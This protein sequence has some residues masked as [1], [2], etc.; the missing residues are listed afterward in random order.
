MVK[1]KSE[2]RTN[3]AEN[4]SSAEDPTERE[5]RLRIRR[6]WDREYRANET[7]EQREHRLQLKRESRMRNRAFE[8]PEQREIRLE[9]ARL[10][11]KKMREKETPEQTRK[12]L[13]RRRKGKLI[14]KDPD[15]P[16]EIMWP[17]SPQREPDWYPHAA[18]VARQRAM[19]SP[20]QVSGRP[21]VLRE[22]VVIG[23]RVGEATGATP[24]GPPL[25]Q[26]GGPMLSFGFTFR[27]L[28]PAH[29]RGLRPIG[30]IIQV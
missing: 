17:M 30:Q 15:I 20:S 27:L 16:G 8:T 14:H 3:Y 26:K 22:Y 4:K 10:W 21:K 23:G 5:A 13:N 18:T 19:P 25:V 24:M 2:I 11:R 28:K 29:R 9:K 6:K 1:T 12:R 7:P